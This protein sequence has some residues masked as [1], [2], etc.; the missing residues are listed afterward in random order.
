MI[1]PAASSPAAALPAAAQR[2]PVAAIGTAYS[3]YVLGLLTL[4]YITNF[5]DRIVLGI[6]VGPIKAELHLSDSQLGLIGGTAF[7]LF[8]TALGIPIGWWA[9]RASRV[10]I[11]TAAL[12][13][14]SLLTALTGFAHSFLTL[15]LARLGVGVGEAGG[16]APA[17]ALIADYFR[18]GWR[19]RVLGFFSLGI[20]IGSALGY[21]LGGYL[22]TAFTWRTAFMWL[23]TVGVVLAPLFLWTVREPE[24]GRFDAAATP[25][26]APSLPEVW[27]VLA[28][29]P[30][31]W[32]LSLAAGCGSLMGYGLLFW[33]PSFFIRSDGMSLLQVSRLLGALLL[34]GGVPGILLGSYI[35][36]RI[37]ARDRR[38]YALVPALA[39]LCIL[40]CYALGTALPMGPAAFVCFLVPAALQLVW[41]GPVIMAIQQLVAPTMRSLASAIFLFINNLLGLGL[42]ALIIGFA[43]DRLAGM[44]GSESLRY[45]ILGGT[46][47]YVLAAALFLAAARR[48]HRD[49]E[50]FTV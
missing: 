10:R 37:G 41:L 29:K 2:P 42:G 9:D 47:F 35:A 16:V 7:A 24:R 4:V 48:L 34:C 28:A 20:P 23:G 27:R 43:S 25:R 12:L 5:I 1:D 46:V 32:L 3:F 39:F 11:M 6:L 33:L 13:C 22:T 44:F 21:L 26:Q 8:Y 31:F 19:A 38:A 14:W 49:F 36:D 18:P 45:A 50:P 40:P 15:F 30:A 17:Y